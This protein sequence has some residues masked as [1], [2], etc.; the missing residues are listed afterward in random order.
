MRRTMRREKLVAEA[1][2]LLEQKRADR[3]GGPKS[4]A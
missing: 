3:K 2:G 1:E 4:K